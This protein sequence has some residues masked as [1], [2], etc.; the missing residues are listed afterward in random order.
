MSPSPC[1]SVRPN[2]ELRLK[3]KPLHVLPSSPLH[4]RSPS[5][6]RAAKG[7]YDLSHPAHH[8]AEKP[9]YPFLHSKW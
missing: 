4:P 9:D 2:L 8:D 6:S 7:A 1:A 3:T 5:S